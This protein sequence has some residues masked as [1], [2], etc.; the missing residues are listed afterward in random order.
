L[1]SVFAFV[2]HECGGPVKVVRTVEGE[3]EQVKKIRSAEH[4]RR[5]N[6]SPDKA[7]KAA[8]GKRLM[9][10]EPKGAK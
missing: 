10:K 1:D 7:I 3:P 9:L 4:S 6:T 5:V 8:D 2:C